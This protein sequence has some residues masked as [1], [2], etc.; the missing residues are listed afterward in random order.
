MNNNNICPIK[1]I[2]GCVFGDKA[3]TK[4]KLRALLTFLY[5]LLSI[6]LSGQ[7]T[8][9]EEAIQLFDKGKYAEALPVFKRMVTMF[10]KDPR[11]Q[12]Y[13]GACMVQTNKD[14]KKALEY[15]NYAA[16]LSV[17]RNVYYFMGK[18]YCYLYMFDDGLEAF[19]KF[20]QYAD[21][22]D[23][24]KWQC[25]M[26]IQM[27]RNGKQIVQKQVILNTL[28]VDTVSMD[29]IYAY[30]N[31]FLNEGKFVEIQEKEFSLLNNKV[32][33]TWR[34]LPDPLDKTQPVFET[35]LNGS[36]H[37]NKDIAVTHR[38]SENEWSKLVNLGTIVNSLYDEDYPYFNPSESALYF[39]SK[40]HNSMG[41]YDIFKSVYDP[42]TKTWSEP[43]NLGY[44]INSPYD[45]FMFVPSEDQ[46]KAIFASNRETHNQQV[47]IYTVSFSK[48]Y[49]FET[50]NSNMELISRSHL[51][52]NLQ[53]TDKLTIS[54]P[55]IR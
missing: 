33:S 36:I 34:F 53:S 19:L 6:P 7:T 55:N 23:K 24:E 43:M 28:H 35:T 20:Q 11:F 21:K 10:P 17:P 44:P 14:L 3:F 38:V 48:T 42:D 9:S 12:Y 31:R 15:L 13:A 16:N 46:T 45:D 18:A 40:G 26:N 5:I 41:G 30:Y 22:T 37:K 2:F 54:S 49:S 47:L 51:R 39:S 52:P 29:N 27:A 4:L 8:S 1:F 32:T 25:D 50:V